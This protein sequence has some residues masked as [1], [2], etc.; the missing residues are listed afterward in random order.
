ML[1][2][3]K[4]TSLNNE[5]EAPSTSFAQSMRGLLHAHQP[6]QQ[7]PKNIANTNYKEKKWAN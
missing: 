6:P 2:L 7:K 3:H 4:K 5:G 1:S